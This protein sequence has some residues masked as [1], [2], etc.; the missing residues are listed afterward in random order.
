MPCEERSIDERRKVGQCIAR[1]NAK[2]FRNDL[3]PAVEIPHE[4]LCDI[5]CTRVEN[6]ASPT[7]RNFRHENLLL[8]IFGREVLVLVLPESHDNFVLWCEYEVL[9]VNK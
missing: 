8:A 4:S 2:K 7:E 3:E 9:N 5:G 6:P 1:N